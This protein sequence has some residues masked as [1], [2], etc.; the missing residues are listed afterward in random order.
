MRE[1]LTELEQCVI[2]VIWR[3]GPM[4][5]YEVAAHFSASLSPYWSGSAGAIYPVVKRLRKRGLLRGVQ[6]AWNGRRKSMLTT[7]PAGK[8]SLRAWLRP[9]LPPEGGGTTFDPIRT[10][11]FFINVLPADQR[12]AFI[13]DAERAVNEQIRLNEEHRREEDAR[14]DLLEALGALGVILELKARRQWLRAVRKHL[15]VS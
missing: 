14:G 1:E 8:A 2:G 10:R 4:T 15:A 9:P 5:A 11:L 3:D 12:L 7:T 13:A 6:R